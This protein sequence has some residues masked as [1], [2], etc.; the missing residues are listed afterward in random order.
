MKSAGFSLDL[1]FFTEMVLRANG[2]YSA[3]S[4]EVPT[5]PRV[6]IFF[7]HR[8]DRTYQM[9]L[10]YTLNAESTADPYTLDFL[11]IG[12]F[13]VD[14]SVPEDDRPKKIAFSGPNILYGALRDQIA[15]MTSRTVWEP[16]LLPPVV[17]GPDDFYTPDEDEE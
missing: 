14:E 13:T 11:L 8:E 6:Q 3:A 1:L 12:T 5:E 2:K 9:G 4:D 17:F 10:G 16:L 7:H 15:T